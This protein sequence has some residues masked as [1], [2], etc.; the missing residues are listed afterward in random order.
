MVALPVPAGRT[1]S[2]ASGISADGNVIVGTVATRGEGPEAGA[3]RWTEDQ[4]SVELDDLFEVWRYSEAYATS[5]DGSV[6]V[7]RAVDQNGEDAAFIWDAVHGMRNLQD[8]LTNDFGFD[9]SDWHL[10]AAYDVSADG[11]TIVG[12][13]TRIDAYHG[14]AWVA[15]IPEPST[16]L[17]ASM[18]ALGIFCH[19]HARRRNEAR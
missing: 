8:V 1:G 17:I 5:A 10:S 19:R 2:T 16:F 12:I 18:A 13:G 15:V 6:I 3:F 14:E 9:L 4:G 7:G 11:R